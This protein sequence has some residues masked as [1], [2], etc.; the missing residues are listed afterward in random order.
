MSEQTPQQSPEPI[1][2]VFERYLRIATSWFV[3]GSREVSRATVK[4][5][6]WLCVSIGNTRTFLR[7]LRPRGNK[8]VTKQVS[9]PAPK[10]DGP[11]L[12]GATTIVADR[13]DDA[14]SVIGHMDVAREVDL[15]LVVPRRAHRLR[16]AIEWSHIAAHVRQRGLHL[17]V[18]TS[19]GDVRQYAEDAGIS[20][21]RTIR[22]LRPRSALRLPLGSRNFVLRMP[23][24]API[25]QAVVLVTV[26]VLAIGAV[27]TY[28]PSAEILIAPP[29][30]SLTTT[31]RVRLNPAGEN[32]FGLGIVGATSVQVTVVS[33]VS[34]A[35]TGTAS[36]GDI[37]A[38]TELFFSNAGDVDI[39]LPI[40]TPVEDVE[41]FTFTT[42]R[43]VTVPA[44]QRMT[45][46]ATALRSG[47][48]G[49]LSPDSLNLLL[50]FPSTLTVTNPTAA[51]GGTDAK[52]PAVSPVDVVTVG[53]LAETVLLRAGQRELLR[54]FKDATVFPETISVSILS[55]EPLAKV[56]EPTDVF[57]MEYTAVVS[58]FAL[59]DADA[60]H[61]AE[62]LLQG[63]LPVG[64][65]LLPGTTQATLGGDAVF[66][67]SRLT[68]DLT[69][70]GLMT[71]LLDPVKLR[72]QLTSVSPD[73]A[74]ERLSRSLGLIEKPLITMHPTWMPDW[75]MPRRSGRI[76]VILVSPEI[77][78]TALEDD[79]DEQVTNSG[80][81]SEATE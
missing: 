76:S 68:V 45:V 63:Q 25:L 4:L 9:A 39:D 46:S 72:G 75:R 48:R 28:V 47:T 17:R 7:V 38:T 81:G 52:L 70:T 15:L 58:A 24:I 73:L 6:H 64:S 29:S 33:V 43:A 79:S 22:G 50:G 40:G 16:D 59:S 37:A 14:S 51:E 67:G 61:A 34:A 30:E 1:D 19:R 3:R 23:P 55:Q 32:D 36:V 35:T 77:L 74:A 60:D 49:N 8:E 57:M 66:D 62:Q 31:T 42:D 11:R 56:G 18:L 26:I 12:P 27:W 80:A 54:T 53:E 41:G 78:A 5:W 2:E 13:N 69:A 65:A 20:A 10:G 71:P 21:A 44:G